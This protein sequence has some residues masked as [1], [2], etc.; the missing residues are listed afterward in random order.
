MGQSGSA[1]IGG[2]WRKTFGIGCKW[3]WHDLACHEI[4]RNETKEDHVLA[5]VRGTDLGQVR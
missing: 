1:R 2:S 4:E 5:G 3:K